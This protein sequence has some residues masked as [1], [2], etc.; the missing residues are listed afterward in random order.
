[1]HAGRHDRQPSHPAGRPLDLS[2]YAITPDRGSVADLL[3][4][5]EQ[6]LAGGVTCLQ[7]RSKHLSIRERTQLAAALLPRCRAAGVPLL[8]NDAVDIALAV[9]ADGVHVGQ[10]DLDARTARRLLG[11]RAVIGVSAETQAE[12]EEAHANGADYVGV[13]PI[14]A[15]QSKADA[16]DPYGPDLIRRLRPGSPL[17]VVAIG[18]I[19]AETAA[20]VIDAGADGI[21]VISAI[22]GSD[23]PAAAARR[24]R[25]IVDD[26]R[27][28]RTLHLL[29]DAARMTEQTWQ[30][31]RLALSVPGVDRLHVRAQHHDAD[32][33]YRLAAA[34]ADLLAGQAGTSP[35][36]ELV[37]HDRCDV[38][39]AVGAA[40]VQLPERG[41]P[42]AAARRVLPQ[43]TRIGR[44]VHDPNGAE[45]AVADGADFLLFGHIFASTSKPGQPPRGVE[46]LRAVTAA[47]R[48]PVIAI[49]GIHPGNAAEALAG[50]CRG[51]AVSD[52]ILQQADPAAAVIALR[53][54][55]DQA[56]EPRRSRRDHHGNFG[57][58]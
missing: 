10:D 9:G 25:T 45:R 38:A 50:G 31:L 13:G 14:Y 12:I 37:V 24:L 18:G 34:C 4:Q 44:S 46:A 7:I 8:I 29:L 28:R 23:D 21:A 39:A 41:L 53:R 20:A 47:S 22:F 36:P 1:M 54:L 33:L 49:G 55:L 42:V 5:C 26:A 52:G 51:I 32:T 58:P 15:T 16:G 3:A 19:A 2:V 17:P 57:Q 43:G 35:R 11:P 30:Q 40:A 27:S 48:V 6:A 56:G